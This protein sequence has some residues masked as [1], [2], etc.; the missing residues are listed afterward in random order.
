[1]SNYEFYSIKIGEESGNL[2]EVVQKL[3]LFYEKKI[4][5]KRIVIAALTYPTI[6][7]TTALIV[8]I[9]MLSYVVPMFQ[10]IFRQNNVELP[11]ITELIIKTSSYVK[12]YLWVIFVVVFLF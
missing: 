4:E 9:F 1:F 11:W 3:A 7:L 2:G 10:D 6:I 5:Q 12:K 8:V